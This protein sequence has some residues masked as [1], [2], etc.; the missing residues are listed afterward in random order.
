MRLKVYK[1]PWQL[2]T[3]WLP[4]YEDF[5]YSP[6]YCLIPTTKSLIAACFP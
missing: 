5:E 6:N 4:M 1:E 2:S 3:V